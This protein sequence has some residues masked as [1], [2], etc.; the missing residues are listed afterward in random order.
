MWVE[1]GSEGSG[2]LEGG[3]GGWDS[4]DDQRWTHNS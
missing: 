3:Q 4:P 2:G 1:G